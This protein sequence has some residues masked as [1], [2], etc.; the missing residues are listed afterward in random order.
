LRLL[1][2]TV[3][4]VSV[5]IAAIAFVLLPM[6][7]DEDRLAKRVRDAAIAWS[8]QEVAFEGDLD[9]ALFPQSLLTVYRPRFGSPDSRDALIADRLDLEVELLPLLLGRV[10]ITEATIVRPVLSVAGSAG[11]AL[12]ALTER[13]GTNG[14]GLPIDR[15]T[16]IDGR[17]SS[18]DDGMV[19]DGID[20][21]VER[22]GEG[23]SSRF[24]LDGQWLS[25]AGARP[26]RINGD[27]AAP[28]P[29]RPVP[30]QV[31][32]EVTDAGDTRNRVAFRGQVAPPSGGRGLAGTLSLELDAPS[33]FASGRIDPALAVLA[34]APLALEAALALDFATESAAWTVSLTEARLLW[35]EQS[36]EGALKLAGGEAPSIELDAT[37]DVLRLGERAGEALTLPAAVLG[38]LPPDLAGSVSLD[39]TLVEWR[40]REFRRLALELRLDGS[41]VIEVASASAVLPGPGDVSFVGSL[42]HRDG[43]S[44]LSLVGTIEAAV[45]NPALLSA[46]FA[47]PPAILARSSTLAVETDI[48]WRPGQV[49]LQNTDLRLDGARIVGG[50]AWRAAASGRLP[51]LAARVSIDRLAVDDLLDE[52]AAMPEQLIDLASAMDLALDLRASRTSLGEARF[53][54]LILRLDSS[55]GRVA[56]ERLALTDIGG[57]AAMLNGQVD[58]GERRYDL[59]VSLDVAS[60]PR[61][62][63]LMGRDPPAALTLLGPLNLRGNLRGDLERVEIGSTLQGDL[64]N[65][66]ARATLAGWRD[67]PSGPLTIDLAIGDAAALVRQLGGLPAADSRL[68][69]PVAAVLGLDLD[70][71]AVQ[72][73][74]AELSLG[75]VG[76]DARVIL[77]ADDGRALDRL[78]LRIGPVGGE[79]MADLYRLATPPLDLVPGPPG[80]WLGN[81]PRQALNWRWLRQRDLEI[82]LELTLEAPSLPPIEIES[83]LRNG[84]LTVPAFRWASETGT[85]S[86][87]LA[88]SA[89]EAAPGIGLALDLA[90]E[91]FSAAAVVER[92]GV[93]SDA[94]DGTLDLEARL[95]TSGT[96]IS[97]LVGNLAGQ[98][99]I[100]ITDGTIGAAPAGGIM[101]DRLNAGLVVER[102]VVRAAPPGIDFVGPD[103]NGRIDGYVDLPAWL[104]DLELALDGANGDPLVRQRFFG[105]LEDPAQLPP[106]DAVPEQKES[107][108]RSP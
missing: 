35:Q 89:S 49:K 88:L 96:S 26:V 33:W 66:D 73:G 44:D 23:G 25:D 21:G 68:D 12:G 50:F 6:A 10:E 92:M 11:D 99:A 30:L 72:G 28:P 77:G 60:L 14:A 93:M 64:F 41:G 48:E 22:Q 80:V 19:V 16:V 67:A 69:G 105:D 81:W 39:A 47:E 85:I 82:A 75:D 15:V 17:L 38:A 87:G 29:G 5:T 104:I 34:E 62:L 108:A 94:L 71:G 51:Q 102:G 101:V 7:L 43:G 61:L 1:I 90:L 58:A 54:G 78:E 52:P 103:G 32:V 95:D 98:A 91:R 106:R 56:I 27:L 53:G 9:V 100:V 79:T 37:A 76:M 63:R 24:Q 20:G 18:V 40:E 42:G 57:S 45:Q 31:E 3:A 70:Q 65:A 86:A 55:G 83:Q 74:R 107:P 8:G 2:G 97:A 59:D 36:F 13:L 46:A 84:R 4:L